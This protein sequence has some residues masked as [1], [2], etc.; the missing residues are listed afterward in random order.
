MDVDEQEIVLYSVNL[1]IKF[2]CLRESGYNIQSLHGKIEEILIEA[3][4]Y[5]VKMNV[6]LITMCF[7]EQA[8]T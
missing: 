2:N 4:F 7:S 3:L 5:K 1:G 6:W 8:C